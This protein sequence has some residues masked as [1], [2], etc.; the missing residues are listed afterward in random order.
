M[1]M[2]VIVAAFACLLG[3]YTSKAHLAHGGI[4]IRQAQL[5]GYR[6]TRLRHGIRFTVWAV[7]LLVILFLVA[8]L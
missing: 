3:W 7:L 4:P 8:K 1:T 6:R 2:V 5:R